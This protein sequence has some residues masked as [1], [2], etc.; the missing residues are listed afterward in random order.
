[1]LG[2]AAALGSGNRAL[3]LVTGQEKENDTSQPQLSHT[4]TGECTDSTC[5]ILGAGR[6]SSKAGAVLR[7]AIEA[8]LAR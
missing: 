2:K 1:M 4:S 6:H 8:A 3:V 5:L 7:P